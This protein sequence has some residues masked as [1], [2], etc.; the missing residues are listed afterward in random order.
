MDPPALDVEADCSDF[1]GAPPVLF[2]CL[3]FTKNRQALSCLVP[4]CSKEKLPASSSISWRLI[5][6]LP[7][8]V[9]KGYFPK[10]RAVETLR[11]PAETPAPATIAAARNH[12]TQFLLGWKDLRMMDANAEPTAAATHAHVNEAPLS[13]VMHHDG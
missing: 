8:H 11:A 2:S 9:R 7:S 4:S 12:S 3:F 1:L 5:V 13:L 10:C 6:H